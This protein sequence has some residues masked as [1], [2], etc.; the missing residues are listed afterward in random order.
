MKYGQM[1]ETIGN[2]L[3]IE[4]NK[5]M[6]TLIRWYLLK[7]K[8]IK[9]KLAFYSFVDQIVN[10]VIN[11]DELQKKILHELVEIIHKENQESQNV[12]EVKS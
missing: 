2:L 4:R 8:E 12:S 11:T 10:E 1:M 7:A 6:I 5:Y 9:I 3:Y